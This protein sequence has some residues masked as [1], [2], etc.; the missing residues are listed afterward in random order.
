MSSSLREPTR[1]QRTITSSLVGGITYFDDFD[2]ICEPHSWPHQPVCAGHEKGSTL[3]GLFSHEVWA[4]TDPE[5]LEWYNES[6]IYKT[7]HTLLHTCRLG[8]EIALLEWIWS[9]KGFNSGIEDLHEAFKKEVLHALGPLL[10]Q[11]QEGKDCPA[12]G[13]TSAE[14]PVIIKY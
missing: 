8:R 3:E 13:T 1:N 9:I 6:T 12:P 5:C 14:K 11:V 7:R 4:M 10:A 2:Y